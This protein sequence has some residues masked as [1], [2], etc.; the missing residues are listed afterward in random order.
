LSWV[1]PLRL[2]TAGTTLERRQFAQVCRERPSQTHR[3]RPFVARRTRPW[4]SEIR[5]ERQDETRPARRCSSSFT[6]SSRTVS[7]GTACNAPSAI[8]RER[9]SNS[10]AHAP[11]TSSAG[12]SRLDSNSSA[13]RARSPRGSRSASARSSSVDMF[14]VYYRVPAAG[15]AVNRPFPR[16]S[17]RV[18]GSTLTG[19]FTND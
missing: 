8:S 19:F 15:R 16:K 3:Q 6:I 2:A 1:L 4:P 7:H 12:S 18:V 13:T 9:R 17:G 5:H 14:S 11:A 10:T